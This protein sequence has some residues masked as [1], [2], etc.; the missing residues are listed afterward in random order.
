MNRAAPIQLDTFFFCFLSR[1]S[2][3]TFERIC[4]GPDFFSVGFFS[5]DFFLVGF[6]SVDFFLVGFFLVGFVLVGFSCSLILCFF[7]TGSSVT[8]SVVLPHSVSLDVIELLGRESKLRQDV[9]A[10]SVFSVFNFLFLEEVLVGTNEFEF[11]LK[12]S[13]VAKN[14]ELEQLLLMP[15]YEFDSMGYSHLS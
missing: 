7:V 14:H 1:R 8:G 4:A 2:L 13:L 9:D 6:F 11:L 12:C 5:V 15:E 3:T 10:F